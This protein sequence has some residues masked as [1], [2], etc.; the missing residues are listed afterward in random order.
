MRAENV[1]DGVARIVGKQTHMWSSDPAKPLPQWIELDLGTPKSFNAV[2]LTFDTDM[3]LRWPAKPLARQC[4]RDYEIACDDGAGGWR[5]HASVKDNFQRWRPHRFP[6]VT[7][8]RIR[9][10]VTR[11]NGDPTARIFEAR[12]YAE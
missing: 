9:I 11:T 5:T 8:R 7:A 10:T 4:V 2:N 3:N 6:T 1:I 12:V